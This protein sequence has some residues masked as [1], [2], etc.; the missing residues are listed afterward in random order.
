MQFSEKRTGANNNRERTRT[1]ANE[2]VLRMKIELLNLQLDHVP[3]LSIAFCVAQCSPF[4]HHVY[5]GV[6]RRDETRN[7]ER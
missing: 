6:R 7:G 4:E 3:A 1:K 5:K 2:S